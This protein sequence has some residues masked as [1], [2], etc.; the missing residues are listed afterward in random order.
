MVT[1]S[2]QSWPPWSFPGG[3]VVKNLSAKREPWVQSLGWEASLEEEMATH[4]GFLAWEILWQETGRYSPW[5]CKRVR[6]DLMTKDQQQPGL[7]GS[8][9]L[10]RHGV[11]EARAST[12]HK[13]DQVSRG[14]QETGQLLCPPG[15]EGELACV[16]SSP[17]ESRLSTALLLFPPTSKGTFPPFGEPRAG[18]LNLR[19]S[20]PRVDIC[21]LYSPYRGHRSQPDCF[22]SLHTHYICIFL[23]LLIVQESFH[24]LWISFQ[25]ELF[26][27]VDV[28]LIWSLGR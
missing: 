8:N 15:L 25:W 14:S 22:S 16:H 17:V 4:P 20:L 3:S 9:V 23:A 28:F 10:L 7:P 21:L 12:W 18:A 5:G 19:L 1:L 11:T 6:H 26:H 13:R 24:Q 27:A 2:P